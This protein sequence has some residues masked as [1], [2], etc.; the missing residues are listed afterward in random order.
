LGLVD[1]PGPKH[2]Q[3]ISIAFGSYLI[4]DNTIG[5]V[6]GGGVAAALSFLFVNKKGC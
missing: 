2:F 3:K 4:I 6:G 1:K 5:L